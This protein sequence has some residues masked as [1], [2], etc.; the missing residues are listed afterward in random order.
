MP[1]AIT[2]FDQGLISAPIACTQGD[3][4]S[5]DREERPVKQ[6]PASLDRAGAY[7]TTKAFI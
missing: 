2:S 6:A 4:S 1:V 3:L 7:L 5:S